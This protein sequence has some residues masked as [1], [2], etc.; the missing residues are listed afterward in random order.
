MNKS[1]YN[2][3]LYLYIINS[4]RLSGKLPKFDSK[5]KR[6]YYINK[7]L[8]DDIIKKVSY[9]TW[10]INK[11]KE[12]Q[13]LKK[14]P[15]GLLTKAPTKTLLLKDIRGHGFVTKIKIPKLDN[16][17]KRS[18][19]LQKKGIKDISKQKKVNIIFIDGW[20]FW[21][22]SKSIIMYA[23]KELD[24][25]TKTAEESYLF[26][27]YKIKQMF[28]KLESLLNIKLSNKKGYNLEITK[29]HYGKVHDDLAK[30]YNQTKEKL[31]VF[32]EFGE[33]WLLVD[34]S[35]NLNEAETMGKRAIS[36]MDDVFKP[37]IND[38]REYYEK[39]EELPLLSTLIK[40]QAGIQ[41]NQQVFDSNMAS[42]IKAV[43][44]LACGVNELRQGIGKLIN[45]ISKPSIS[46]VQDV[47]KNQEYIK[48]LS[49]EEKEEIERRLFL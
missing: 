47:L 32:D 20:Q 6:Q 40:N 42:H 23:P 1:P 4:I 39:T 29:Q 35:L 43:Q 3:K 25:L 24:L 37:F 41:A 11:E 10:E 45:K 38:V 33:L 21:L 49:K 18:E 2:K 26:Y 31:F 17:E 22:C 13:Q 14:K 28:K 16:W 44:S 5:Q 48:T 8:K 27:M 9:G 34:N 36:R 12:V 15:I 30:L 19:Y 7:L 46:N